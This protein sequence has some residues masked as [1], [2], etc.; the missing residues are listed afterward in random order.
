MRKGSIILTFLGAIALS[1]SSLGVT[2]AAA[3]SP[4]SD[5]ID[6]INAIRQQNGLASLVERPQLSASAQPYATAMATGGFF[7]HVGLDGSTMVSRDESAGYTNWAYLAENLA[8]GQ[9]TPAAAVSAWM[10][11]P[12]H[13]ASILSP[14]L[15]D[16]GVGYVYLDGSPYGY[17]WV[18]EFGARPPETYQ[19][20]QRF[21]VS[22]N[23][24]HRATTRFRH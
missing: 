20:I 16:T 5:V 9:Q 15:T 12:G 23:P 19:A 13:R 3:A 7:G 6:Q 4:A 2:A 17:Y 8:A 18:Q 11:S 21:P 22:F 14:N 24:T 1:I 10:Q